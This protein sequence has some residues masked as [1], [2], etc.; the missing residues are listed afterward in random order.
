MIAVG[1]IVRGNWSTI[2]YRADHVW[3]LKHEGYWCINGRCPDNPRCTGSFSYLG[4]RVGNEI[5]IT[6]PKRPK[7][8]LLV[9]KEPKQARMRKQMEFDLQ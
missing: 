6:D 2:E 5:L 3:S 8:R 7:D 9:I 4:E 1:A